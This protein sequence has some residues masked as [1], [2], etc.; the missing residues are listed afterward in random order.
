MLKKFWLMVTAVFLFC[1]PAFA[2]DYV[3]PEIP[4]DWREFS[5]A[6]VDTLYFDAA[7]CE[8]DPTTDTVQVWMRTDTKTLRETYVTEVTINFS[9]G[10][11]RTSSKGWLYKRGTVREFMNAVTESPIR[12]GTY[13]E[14]LAKA[15]AVYVGR[16]AKLAAHQSESAA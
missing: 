3:P 7:R 5:V 6:D 2:A 15:V 4:G 9:A 16:D 14:K 12:K 8:Y 1:C 10:T 13:G 11:M